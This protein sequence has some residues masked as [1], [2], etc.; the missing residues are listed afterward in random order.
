MPKNLGPGTRLKA[1]SGVRPHVSVVRPISIW[2]AT[3]MAQP[4]MISQS[5]TKPAS[6]PTIVVAISS[7][8]PTMELART[9]PGP[10]CA[11]DCQ[12]V[13]GGSETVDAFSMNTNPALRRPGCHP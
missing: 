12:S 2:A 10:R 13:C 9:I 4:R 8:L 5:S 11:S 1:S 3:L 6:A 7:P